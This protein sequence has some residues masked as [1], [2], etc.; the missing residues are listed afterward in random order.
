MDTRAA[1]WLLTAAVLWGTTGT[2]QALG[3]AEGSPLAVGAMRLAIG[4]VG[5]AVLG[6]RSMVRPPLRWLAVGGGAMAVYQV[7]F[8]SGV[9]RVGVALGT[10]V[11]IGSAPIVA[12]ILA[13][14]TRGEVP[15]PR[16]WTATALAVAGVVAIAGQPR[17][18]DVGGVALA[19]L[20]GVAYAAAT[21]ASKYL[22][23]VM[24]PTAAMASMFAVA[25]ALLLPLLPGADLDWLTR[26]RGWASALWLGLAATAAAYF[27]FARGLRRATVGQAA[28]MGLA[29]PATATLLGLVLLQERPP[30]VAWV[31]VA[32]V[33]AALVVLSRRQRVLIA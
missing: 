6:A 31:G 15:T 12:G 27:A 5:L 32:L 2:A 10:V 29:E 17:D 18:V 11:T 1:L 21:L 13:W 8:F 24:T 26:P 23:D 9:G 7:G 28:T 16:W 20:A 25:S 22:L 19:L 33:G 4:S 30:P 3:G 14:A